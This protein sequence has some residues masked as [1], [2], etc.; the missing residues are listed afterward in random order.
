MTEPVDRKTLLAQ[1]SMQLQANAELEAAADLSNRKRRCELVRQFLRGLL[2]DERIT[3]TE[4]V[5]L[6]QFREENSISDAVFVEA[7]KSLHMTLTE[8]DRMCVHEVSSTPDAEEVSETSV[9]TVS[10]E[11]LCVECQKQP[12]THVC[13]PSGA[14]CLC[15]SCASA[16]GA[17]F[18]CPL[19]GVTCN[20]ATKIFPNRLAL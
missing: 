1:L 2:V 8:F 16:K 14:F 15:E 7:L 10:P 19:T 11:V 20:K 18:E 5:L 13:L 9:E 12:R 6:R 17:Q 4:L 3:T